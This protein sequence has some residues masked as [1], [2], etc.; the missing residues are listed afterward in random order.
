MMQIAFGLAGHALLIAAAAAA[1]ARRRRWGR[2]ARML[3]IALGLASLVPLA[4]PSL[5]G[6]LFGLVGGLSVSTQALLALA[7]AS[8]LSGRERVLESDR[9]TLLA[10]VATAAFVL[11][12]LSL[13]LGGFDPYAAGYGS[14]YLLGL[15]ALYALAAWFAGRYFTVAVITAALAAH[16]AGL[17]ESDNL[18]DYLIDAPLAAYAIGG[19]LW[20][21][22]QRV[23]AARAGE[24]LR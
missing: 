6:H 3:P 18:W 16:L 20:V 24:S 1:I 8:F 7:I 15:L 23:R 5:A 13:G 9:R 22:A 10:S 14:P 17:M 11:Y 12:P 4:G 2:W 19:W 21:A